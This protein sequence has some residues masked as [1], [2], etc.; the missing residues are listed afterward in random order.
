MVQTRSAPSGQRN[1]TNGPRCPGCLERDELIAQLRKVLKQIQ[2]QF[3]A[4]RERSGRHAGNSSMPPSSNPPDAPKLKS[5]KKPSGRKRGGQPGHPPANRDMVPAEQ[6]AEPPIACIPDTCAHCAAALSGVDP[7]PL[8]HQVTE[9]PPII[10]EVREYQRHLLR[11]PHCGEA[12]RGQL[13][14]GVPESAFGPRLQALIGLCTGCYHLSKR[15]TEEL[16]TTALNVPIS[17]GAICRVEQQISAALAEPVAQAHEHLRHSDVAHADETSWKQQPHK[18]WLWVGV[19]A[20]LAVF[21]I[22]RKRDRT[23]ARALLGED[24]SG[25]LV[26]DRYSVYHGIQRR[27]ICWAHLRREW[28]AF[29]DRGG[30]SQRIGQGLLDLTDHMFGEWQRVRDGTLK[31]DA[32]YFRMLPVR[33]QVAAWLRQGTHCAHLET[34]ATCREI[35]AVEPALWT[36]ADVAGVEPTNNTAERVLRQAVLWRK[37][38]F[39]TRSPAGSQYVERILTVVASCRLQGRNALEYLTE[40]CKAILLHQPAP[41]LVPSRRRLP[42]TPA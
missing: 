42:S 24:F 15:Q 27:Q 1:A 7:L 19:T 14:D 41:S 26:S 31:H 36:F 28:Q 21:L 2:S 35:L 20:F 29:I 32:F 13:P 16:L 4:L 5:R 9:L 12:T 23:S 17:L 10:P 37:K 3:Q 22:R 34:S 8:R 33:H 6:L 18:A 38:S 25:V 30:T 11:C 40:A 39:G